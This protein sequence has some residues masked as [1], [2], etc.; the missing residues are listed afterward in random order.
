MKFVTRGFNVSDESNNRI[1][2]LAILPKAKGIAICVDQ[3]REGTQLVPLQLIVGV[4]EFAWVCAFTRCL[5]FNKPDECIVHRDCVVGPGFQIGYRRWRRP[6]PS[7]DSRA[8]LFPPADTRKAPEF[9]LRDVRLQLYCSTSPLSSFRKWQSLT[10]VSVSLISFGFQAP[11]SPE[12]MDGGKLVA[13][14]F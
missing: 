8:R 1:D 4:P 3:V 5:Q 6:R 9:D 7:G 12:L 13:Q 2:Q 14:S 10:Q 11:V